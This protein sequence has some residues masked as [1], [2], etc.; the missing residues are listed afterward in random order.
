[1]FHNTHKKKENRN[2]LAEIL[3]GLAVG[4]FMAAIEHVVEK[5]KKN[6]A[7]K[8]PEPSVTI[9]EIPFKDLSVVQLQRRL[10]ESLAKENYETAAEIRDLIKA[11]SVNKV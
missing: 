5:N 9:S 10:K 7:D 2:Y 6:V 4:I 8:N 11:K 3:L 1:M